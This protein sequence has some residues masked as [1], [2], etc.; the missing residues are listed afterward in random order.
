MK[1][2]LFT[3]LLLLLSLLTSKERPGGR[4]GYLNDKRKYLSYCRKWA[5]V[6]EYPHF[7]LPPPETRIIF[8]GAELETSAVEQRVSAEESDREDPPPPYTP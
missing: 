7:V 5:Y 2:T 6:D 1:D 3:V 4:W 8:V